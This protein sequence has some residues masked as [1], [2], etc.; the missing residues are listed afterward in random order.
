MTFEHLTT[1]KGGEETLVYSAW[2]TNEGHDTEVYV[3]TPHG[4]ETTFMVT[5][6]TTGT[7]PHTYSVSSYTNSKGEEVVKSYIPTKS[8]TETITDTIVKTSH[9][10]TETDVRVPTPSGFTSY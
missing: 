4:S 9:G 10:G 6:D 7:S 3:K 1:K 2:K 5:P 8:G